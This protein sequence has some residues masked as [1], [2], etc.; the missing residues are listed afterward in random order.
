[1]FLQV[2]H[3]AW[4]PIRL[5]ADGQA[6]FWS[7]PFLSPF[8]RTHPSCRLYC[9]LPLWR[10]TAHS[11]KRAVCICTGCDICNICFLLALVPVLKLQAKRVD[12]EPG[13]VTVRSPLSLLHLTPVMTD[14]TTPHTGPFSFFSWQNCSLMIICKGCGCLRGTVITRPLLWLAFPRS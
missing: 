2:Q 3:G 8:S 13:G 10:S 4:L 6:A 1:M 14:I 5:L 12:W 7:A 9:F 11:L